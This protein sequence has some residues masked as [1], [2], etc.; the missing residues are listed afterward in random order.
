MLAGPDLHHDNPPTI[1]KFAMM[2]TALR[3]LLDA[4]GP[5][6]VGM[7]RA[8]ARRP[9]RRANPLSPEPERSRYGLAIDGPALA[10]L[11]RKSELPVPSP[12]RLEFVAMMMSQA[13]KDYLRRGERDHDDHCRLIE[14]GQ[15]GRRCGTILDRRG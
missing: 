9:R 12:D 5:G 4:G 8:G 1:G 7:D 6:D 11:Y 3:A 2:W 10:Q 13:F 15:V 14:L